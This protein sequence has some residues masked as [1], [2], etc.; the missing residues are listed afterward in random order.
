[1]EH[2]KYHCIAEAKDTLSCLDAVSVK[3]KYSAVINGTELSNNDILF[4]R[5]VTEIH[6]F[7]TPSIY[8]IDFFFKHT[9]LVSLT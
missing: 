3:A 2:F 8:I 1:M 7:H 6:I 5:I 4:L 9:L